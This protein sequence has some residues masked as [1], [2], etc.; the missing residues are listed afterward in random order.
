VTRMTRIAGTALQRLQ[1]SLNIFQLDSLDCLSE[2]AF[3]R[4]QSHGRG[5][6]WICHE[7][8]DRNAGG[9]GG[10]LKPGCC[11]V[12][13]LAARLQVTVVKLRDLQP[14]KQRFI[15]DATYPEAGREEVFLAGPRGAKAA[16]F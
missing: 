8:Q 16:R 2:H 13:N 10:V 11:L 15:A 6:V 9:T 3:D 1:S 5:D 14:P 7:L 4:P 12:H